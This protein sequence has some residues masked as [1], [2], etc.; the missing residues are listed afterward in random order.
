MGQTAGRV[1]SLS[2]PPLLAPP[3]QGGEMAHNK[4]GGNG[5]WLKAHVF[6]SPPLA[7]PWQGG[8]ENGALAEAAE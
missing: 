5:K 7:P 8:E 1:R 3:Y 2:V 6:I 4:A